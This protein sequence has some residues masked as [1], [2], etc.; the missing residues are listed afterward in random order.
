MICNRTLNAVLRSGPALQTVQT[1]Q[2]KVLTLTA[3]VNHMLP[4]EQIVKT[5]SIISVSCSLFSS[6]RAQDTESKGLL[7]L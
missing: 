2:P 7:F 1:V 5:I 4:S 6:K 3:V